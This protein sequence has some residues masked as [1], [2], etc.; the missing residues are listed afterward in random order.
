MLCGSGDGSLGHG[1]TP[2]VKRDHQ[3][4]PWDGQ[5]E[6]DLR[7]EGILAAGYPGRVARADLGPRGL[8]IDLREGLSGGGAGSPQGQRPNPCQAWV[9]G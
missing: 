5:K 7:E 2:V 1:H 9:G 8:N 6:K 3:Q 4:G